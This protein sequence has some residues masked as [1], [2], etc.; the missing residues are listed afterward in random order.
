MTAM[1]TPVEDHD[2]ATTLSDAVLVVDQ[3]GAILGANPVAERMFGY[4]REEL[5]GRPIED[6]V[7]ERLRAGHAAQRLSKADDVRGRKMGQGRPFPALRRDGTEFLVEVALT[8]GTDAMGRAVTNAVVRD[9][10]DRERIFA[11]IGGNRDKLRALTSGAFDLLWEATFV[12][13]NGDGTLQLFRDLGPD[14]GYELGEFP[15][16]LTV[17]SW[18]SLMPE[19]DAA[20]FSEVCARAKESGG[21]VETEYRLRTKSGGVAWFEHHAQPVEFHDGKPVKYL[22]ASRNITARKQAEAELRQANE[23]LQALKERLE[24]ENVLLA[25]EIE[26]VQGFDEIVGTSAVL[27]QVL[28]QIGQVAPSSSSVLITGETGTGKELVAHAIHRSS[29]RSR[30]PVRGAE[31]RRPAAHPHRERAV[32]PRA[33]R[34]HRGVR[35]ARGPLRTWRT[36]ARSSSTKS[37][38]CRWT[39]RP[40]CCACSNRASAS[41]VGSSDSFTV[42]VRLIAAT[43][44]DLRAG[45]REGHLPPGPLLPAERVPDRTCRRFGSGARTSRCWCRILSRKRPRS[46]GRSSIGSLATSLTS[47]RSTTGLATCA[48]SRT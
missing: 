17:S 27:M 7:P 6:L 38:T 15:R 10:T 32:R 34:V 43:N 42:D 28:R 44:R 9:V 29:P 37:A 3:A 13:D 31:L 36:A 11:E 14:L 8:P 48:S 19:D 41:V 16:T 24:N 39:C 23:Q 33:R 21:R 35:A 22:G 30:A 12:G 4:S 2:T 46:S 20:S 40:S 26:R 5:V 47:S 45:D 25:Q 18:L 1:T